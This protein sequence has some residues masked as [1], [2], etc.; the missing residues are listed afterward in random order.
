MTQKRECATVNLTA[1][2]SSNREAGPPSSSRSS[3]SSPVGEL[4]HVASHLILLPAQ[5][6]ALSASSRAA[7]AMVRDGGGDDAAHIS[8]DSGLDEYEE[9]V[10]GSQDGAL[11]SPSATSRSS[12]E[13]EE[14]LLPGAGW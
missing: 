4:R 12:A 5:V 8:T 6:A 11:S 2:L 14:A 13:I 1:G 10:G 7:A 3:S 9:G